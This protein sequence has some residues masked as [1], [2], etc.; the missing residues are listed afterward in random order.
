[1]VD[2]RKLEKLALSG[3]LKRREFIKRAATLSLAAPFATSLILHS[4]HAAVP[5]KGG[6]FVMG[7]GYGSTTDSLI[8]G[9]DENGFISCVSWA[10]RNQLTEIDANGQTIPDLAESYE[11]SADAKTWTFKLRQGVEFHNGKTMTADDVIPS[12]NFHRGE[13]TKSAGKAFLVSVAS[14]TKKGKYEVEFKL[15]EGNA[16]FPSIASSG[17]FPIVPAKDGALDWQSYVGTGGYT[18]EKFEPGVR[19]S[20]KRN[21]NY[22]K[23]GRAH[24]DEVEMLALLDTTARQNA[25]MNGE[26]HSISRVDPKTVHL[27]RRVKSLK[28]VEA[29]G[30]LPLRLSL[31]AWMSRRLTIM[32]YVWRSSCRLIVNKWLKRSCWTM[33][34]SV[35]IIRSQLL[36]LIIMVS[37]PNVNT[38][39][40]RLV[41]T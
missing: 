33:V 11:A 5:K 27:M 12:F 21:P 14:I 34:N 41:F 23:S 13:S 32:I 2:I 35:T 38:I 17:Q 1:M 7:L 37:C 30:T 3:D 20:F 6:R 29:T 28:I 26:V 8:P 9:Q 19:A 40:T 16:D 4:A 18:L 25:A 22:F 31:C 36:I 15:E 10:F 39:R 24:F